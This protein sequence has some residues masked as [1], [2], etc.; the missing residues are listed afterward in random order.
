[1]CTLP[2]ESKLCTCI[3]ATGLSIIYLLQYDRAWRKQDWKNAN[4]SKDDSYIAQEGV[5]NK[6]SKPNKCKNRFTAPLF[7]VKHLRGSHAKPSILLFH[8]QI[9][10]KGSWKS[11]TTSSSITPLVHTS[12]KIRPEEKTMNTLPKGKQTSTPRTCFHLVA[13]LQST[14]S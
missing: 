2:N 9:H 6:Q 1:M 7:L 4:I 10:P 8:L 11:I 5:T 14:L 13:G 3:S 12:K